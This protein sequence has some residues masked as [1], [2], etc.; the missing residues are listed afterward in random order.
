[1]L[2]GMLSAE[3]RVANAVES[4]AIQMSLINQKI[5]ILIEAIE[6]TAHRA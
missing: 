1:M 4:I 6:R 2:S 5:D 3:H